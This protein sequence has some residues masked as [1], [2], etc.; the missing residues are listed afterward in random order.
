MLSMQIVWEWL[1]VTQ[2]DLKALYKSQQNLN[3]STWWCKHNKYTFYASWYHKPG[4]RLCWPVEQVDDP[5][6]YLDL[7][8]QYF[9]IN[10]SA[11]LSSTM[12]LLILL[13]IILRRGIIYWCTG[14]LSWDV[15]LNTDVL[16]SS[17]SLLQDSLTLN[18]KGPFLIAQWLNTFHYK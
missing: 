11:L 9:V 5:S 13:P 14:M 17:I 12:V 6:I 7:I 4:H 18:L 1:F 3:C 2:G 15:L 8:L 10:L 16:V